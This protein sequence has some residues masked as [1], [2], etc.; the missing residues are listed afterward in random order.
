[1]KHKD[2]KWAKT[3]H[4]QQAFK[5]LKDSATGMIMGYFNS[6]KR[7]ELHV[8]GLP[9]ELDP[10]LTQTMPGEDDKVI[11]YASCLLTATES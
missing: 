7:T 11:A 10:I 6:S 9:F 2:V 3:P 4:Q 1:M 5:T 8:D